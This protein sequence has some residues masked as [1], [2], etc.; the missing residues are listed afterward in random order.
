[1]IYILIKIIFLTSVWVLGLTIVTQPE[2]ALG[3][4]R[5]WAEIKRRAIFEPIILCEWCMP[6]IHS[7]IGFAFAFALHVIPFKFSWDYVLMYPLVVMGSSFVCGMLW[8]SWK[9]LEVKISYFSNIEKLA[10]YDVADRKSR[11]KRTVKNKTKDNGQPTRSSG[12][13][14]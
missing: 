9:L 6:S 1:M 14:V 13:S 10:H 11:Y 7:L 8:N 4:F 12:I 3:E 2:M 5:R